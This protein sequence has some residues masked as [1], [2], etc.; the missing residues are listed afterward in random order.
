MNTIVY[1][2]NQLSGDVFAPP[3]KNYTT[4]FILAAALA[5]G[6]SKIT[7]P[8]GNDDAIAMIRC[9]RQLGAEFQKDGEDL[10]ISGVGGRLRPP[11]G[12]L[13]VG[14]GGAILR[15]L[16]GIA[17]LGGSARFE[18]RYSESLGRRPHGD[19]L[20]ALAY[21]GAE[22]R[23]D[24]GRLPI[25]I[26]TAAVRGGDVSVSGAVSSQFTSALLFLAPLLSRGMRIRVLPPLRSPAGVMTTLD[27]LAR[28]GIRVAASDDLLQFE[29]A[30][31][32]VYQAGQFEVPGDYPAAAAL[33]AAAAMVPS[34]IRIFGLQ[35]DCQAERNAFGLFDGM[36][37]GISRGDG[38]IGIHGSG[39]HLKPVSCR[40]DEVV[41][42]VLSLAT[43]AAMAEGKSVFSDLHNLR[44][45]ESDRITDFRLQMR[46]LGV[47][48][49]ENANS[50]TVLG[51]APDITAPGGARASIE[52]SGRHDHRLVMALAARALSCAGPVRILG[53]DAVKKSYP[54]FFDDLAALGAAVSSEYGQKPT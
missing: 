33:A 15:F 11:A 8:A 9:C 38:Y 30:G 40:G 22:I 27:V 2:C 25:E 41:D 7:R 51:P 12:P 21:L 16:L 39:G 3:S 50:M 48:I 49:I 14:N 19:L 46:R 36:G 28:M 53:S 31:G 13:D 54:A 43:A 4:R 10:L 24:G 17:G 44:L 42:A 52:V 20:T 35:P 1:R 6:E 32:Q 23:S 5:G 47:Q 37:L 29:I 45:K 34:N 26:S 18:T